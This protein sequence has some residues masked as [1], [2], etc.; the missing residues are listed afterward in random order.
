MANTMI[1]TQFR[2]HN[3]MYEHTHSKEGHPRHPSD[4]EAG[5]TWQ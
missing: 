5:V 1:L 4:C 2:K 3:G